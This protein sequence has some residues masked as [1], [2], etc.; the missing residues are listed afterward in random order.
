M[1]P[2]AP[3]EQAQGYTQIFRASSKRAV[4]DHRLRRGLAA[5][6]FRRAGRIRRAAGDPRLSRAR[7]AS[8]TATSCLIPSS[9]HGTNPASAVMAGMKVVVVACDAT[10][11]STSTICAPRPSSTR[12]ARGADGHLS[13]DARRVRG[14]HPRDL[15]HRA[16]ARRPGL[17]GRRQHERAG[18][19]HRP[20]DYR[21]R[22]LP[23]QPAQDVLHSAR[24]RRPG[25]G[26]DRRG[27]ASRAVPARP[28]PSTGGGA[29]AIGGPVSAAPWGS[30]SI[31]PISYIYIR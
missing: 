18:R 26:A 17:H 15:R 1:H 21:R 22:R 12:H 5:A 14:A 29:Q 7:A 2:F 11:T 13:L 28:S 19:A 9:A 23:P 24:R 16:R 4:R 27:G 6:E 10:A 3:R 30:A 31:L 20:G 8:R 25:H